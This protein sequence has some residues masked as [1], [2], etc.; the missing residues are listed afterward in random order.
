M[1][2]N[3]E[4]LRSLRLEGNAEDIEIELNN[5]VLMKLIVKN[6]FCSI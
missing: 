5:L 4:D 6:T 1:I 3:I 2:E